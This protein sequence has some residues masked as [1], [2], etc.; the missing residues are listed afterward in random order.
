MELR[1]TYSP[2]SLTKV[3]SAEQSSA[4]VVQN[5]FLKN[6][7]IFTGKHLCRGLFRPATL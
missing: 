1:E 3:Y 4:D 6:L 2:K 7:A 5:R